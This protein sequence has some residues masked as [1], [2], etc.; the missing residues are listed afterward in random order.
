MVQVYKP[1]SQSNLATVFP[2]LS[3]TLAWVFSKMQ[4]MSWSQIRETNIKGLV[5]A[6]TWKTLD[7]SRPFSS[8]AFLRNLI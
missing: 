2:S 5:I 8:L 1:L 4:T 3:T 6:T 7:I